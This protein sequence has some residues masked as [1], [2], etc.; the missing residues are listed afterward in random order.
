MKNKFISLIIYPLASPLFEQVTAR[1][2]FVNVF[3]F[4][5][6]G[7]R[8]QCRSKKC[9]LCI[10]KP[11]RASSSRRTSQQEKWVNGFLEKIVK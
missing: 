3:F 8:N 6:F 1:F 11:F 10:H 2:V 4:V 9:M 7:K 5:F